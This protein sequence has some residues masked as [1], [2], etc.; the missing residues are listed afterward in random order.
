MTGSVLTLEIFHIG[1]SFLRRWEGIKWGEMSQSCYG[2]WTVNVI[3]PQAFFELAIVAKIVII[4]LDGSKW[5]KK[6]Q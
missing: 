2:K 1:C 4:I 3:W 6:C 5:N